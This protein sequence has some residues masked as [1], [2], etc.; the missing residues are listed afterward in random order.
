M[1][2][3]RVDEEEDE[4]RGTNSGAHTHSHTRTLALAVAITPTA[5]AVAVACGC[6]ACGCCC[7]CW[8]LPSPCRSPPAAPINRADEGLGGSIKLPS[9]VPRWGAGSAA[10]GDTWYFETRALHWC[11]RA[12]GLAT[13]SGRGVMVRCARAFRRNTL[14]KSACAIGRIGMRG[15]SLALRGN[16][17]SSGSITKQAV[18][19]GIQ[20]RSLVVVIKVVSIIIMLSSYR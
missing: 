7:C 3:T 20:A 13:E 2:S 10:G 5:A 8:P 4:G 11:S 18:Y 16:L 15:I 12:L 14:V 17:S 19:I 6:D 9:G 1:R